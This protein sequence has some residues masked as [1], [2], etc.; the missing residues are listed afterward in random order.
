M[1]PV[2]NRR[3]HVD[4]LWTK[5]GHPVDEPTAEKPPPMK[6]TNRHRSATISL[7]A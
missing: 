7:Q 3:R 4:R 1:H 5:P 6:Q 2:D